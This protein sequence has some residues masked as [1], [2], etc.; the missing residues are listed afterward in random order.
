MLRASRCLLRVNLVNE[1]FVSATCQSE[2]LQAA[3]TFMRMVLLTLV[4]SEL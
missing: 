3:E 2:W 1:G 4:Y